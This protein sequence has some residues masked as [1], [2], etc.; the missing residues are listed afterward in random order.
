MTEI[1]LAGPARTPVGAFF[2]AFSDVPAVRLG[3][4]AIQ[5]SLERARVRPDQ[6]DEIYFGNVISAG[7]GQNVARQVALGAGLPTS[8][9]ATTVNK[10]CGSGLRAIVIAAQTIRAGDAQLIVAGGTE[11]MTRAPYL[12]PKARGGYKLGHGELLDA[13]IRD[14]LSDAY[15]GK[16]MA[17]YAEEVAAE[18]RITREQQDD[19]AIESFRRALAAQGA[20]HFR[21]VMVSVEVAGRRSTSV[22]DADEEP[23]KFIEDKFRALKPAFSP[24]GTITAGNASAISDGA[25]AVV[26][27]SAARAKTLGISGAGRI[28]GHATASLEPGRF[29]VA[30][31]HALRKLSDQLSLKLADVDLFEINEA[32]APVV[33]AAMRE[34]DL[35]HDRVNIFGGAI[36]LGHPIGASGARI[37]TALLDGLRI[38]QKRIGV[39]CLC[40]GGGEASAVA[41]ERCR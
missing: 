14:G 29:P 30:P 16:H 31:I 25:A 32:F 8:C 38:R 10:M 15:S 23:A 17:D 24:A 21:E 4:L 11:N 13:M 9:G 28:L 34:L 7:L 35:P 33:L 20:G 2:G 37:V 41:I 6:V 1:L 19:Y 3:S 39:A 22:V 18:Y 40:I 27:V 5:G 12:L 26:V 36:A